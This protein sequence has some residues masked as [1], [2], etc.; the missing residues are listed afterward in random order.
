MNW[1][2][3]CS[4][5]T[6][7]SDVVRGIRARVERLS[8]TEL[9]ISYRLDGDIAQ[10]R[11]PAPSKACIGIELWRHTCFEAFIAMEKQ[12]AYHELNFAPSGDWTVY[13]F[14]DYRQGSP[15]ADESMRPRVTLRRA[16]H[17]LEL[18]A[19]IPLARLSSDYP[20]APL[21]LGLA[22]IVEASDG[23]SYWALHHPAEKPD[24]HLVQG[25][26]LRLEPS[27]RDD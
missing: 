5:P 4:H 10:I 24:F 19:L 12:A 17:R 18:D 8:G 27:T 13:S 22:A 6:T 9:R 7:R 2:D 15:L 1:I 16:T 25:F 21:R 23:F 14:S 20:R 3:L 11:V 26:T